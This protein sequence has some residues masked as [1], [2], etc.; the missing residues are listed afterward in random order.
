MKKPQQIIDL[1]KYLGFE[2]IPIDYCIDVGYD[3]NKLVQ[4]DFA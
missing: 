4:N 2:L 3:I 1:E